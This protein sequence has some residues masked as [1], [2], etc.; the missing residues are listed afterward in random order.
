[1]RGINA[2]VAHVTAHPEQ[3]P[4]EFQIAGVR[5]VPWTPEV[6]ISRMAGYVMT[7]NAESEV[8]RARLAHAVGVARVAEFMPPD[9]PVAVMVPDGL[10]LADLMADVLALAADADAPCGSTCR[11][12]PRWADSVP[13][14]ARAVASAFADAARP[15]ASPGPAVALAGLA[16]AYST[17]GSN[18]WVVSGARSASGRPCSRTIRTGPCACRRCDTRFTST[19]RAGT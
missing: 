2:Q 19:G 5:P 15:H 17:V 3:L 16:E 4:L 8:Q 7:R 18:N 6:V 12:P 11:P 13:R 1:V 10:D 9:P 14:T